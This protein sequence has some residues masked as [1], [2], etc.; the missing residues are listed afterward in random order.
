[1]RRKISIVLKFLIG[2]FALVGVVVAC[3]FATRDG[4]SHWHKRLFYFT[5]Q[6]NLWIGV[7]SLI[8]GIMY[9]IE[10]VKKK[11]IVKD[12]WHVLRFV[13]TVSITITGIIFCCLLAPFAG[14]DYNAWS[15]SSFATHVF[16]P[17]FSIADLFVDNCEF[18]LKKRHIFY[19]FVDSHFICTRLIIFGLEIF[20]FLY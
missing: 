15:F 4:Y 6:S 3:F 17:L 13:F 12:Y 16:V 11:K 1:M 10:N 18:V 7:T 9:V 14:E 5:Q 20:S 19:S 8:V 2:A